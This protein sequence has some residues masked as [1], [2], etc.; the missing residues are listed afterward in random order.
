M[1]TA[2]EWK[3]VVVSNHEDVL[4][5]KTQRPVIK[6]LPRYYLAVGENTGE[7][8]FRFR[9]VIDA[10]G[11]AVKM[12]QPRRAAFGG[13]FLSDELVW[14]VEVER[15]KIARENPRFLD[16][17]SRT[18]EGAGVALYRREP[19]EADVEGR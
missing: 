18:C 14:E 4:P 3:F 17:F 19:L 9:V 12:Q 13:R 15:A 7:G 6:T 1:L 5:V 11:V 8:T 10:A 16:G 2:E